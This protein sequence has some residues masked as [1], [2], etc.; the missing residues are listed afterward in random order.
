M[1]ESSLKSATS[2]ERIPVPIGVLV[3][4]GLGVATLWTTGEGPPVLGIAAPVVLGFVAV[5]AGFVVAWTKPSPAL[6]L[7]TVTTTVIAAFVSGLV[8]IM[9]WQG[10]MIGLINGVTYALCLALPV[11][12][13]AAGRQRRVYVRRGWELAR[14]EAGEYDARV[15]QAVM[16]ER[17]AMAGE[18]HDDLGHRL[19]L[20]AVQ[21]ARLSLD[22]TLPASTR[23]ELKSIRANA[24]DAADA[25]GE[26]VRLLTERTSDITASLTGLGFD[27]V[28]G[29]ARSSGINVRDEIPSGAEAAVNEYSRAALL[30]IVQEGLTNA[31]KHAP[32]LPVDIS[33]DLDVDD[34][35]LRMHNASPAPS[36]SVQGHGIVALQ[37]RVTILGG[38]L[39]VDRSEGFTLAVRIPRSATPSQSAAQSDRT[40]TDAVEFEKAHFSRNRRE[41][42]QLALLTPAVLLVVAALSSIGYFVY[43][44]F[45]A[46]LP[47]ERF[48]TISV[49]DAQTQTQSLLP[50]MGMFDAPRTVIAEPPNA[51]C[52]YYEASV[53]FFARDDVFRICFANGQVVSTDTIPAP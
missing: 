24:A 17:D 6:I 2:R 14:A 11:L 46:E 22:A 31:A 47:P 29:R 38:A 44:N 33:M 30:R 39:T 25:L 35:V 13:A 51:T 53:T 37:H 7:V 34:V 8:S 4:A 26:T 16:R 48:A 15:Q 40:R 43:A 20:I 27:D 41:A 3:G 32:G 12:V 45:A 21:T 10:A 23:V 5:V 50:E 36:S 49:G 1:T 18:I 19:T 52:A 42:A 9:P 28:I